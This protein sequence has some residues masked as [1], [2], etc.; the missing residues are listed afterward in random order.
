[1]RSNKALQSDSRAID[2]ALRALLLDAAAAERNRWT[3]WGEHDRRPDFRASITRE[4]TIY[5]HD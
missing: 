3:D 5:G 2:G 1:M 4:A